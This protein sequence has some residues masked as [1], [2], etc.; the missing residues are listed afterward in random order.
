[1]RY[2][3]FFICYHC[4]LLVII[5]NLF[6]VCLKWCFHCWAFGGFIFHDLQGQ[7]QGVFRPWFTTII[8]LIFYY[9]CKKS[10]Q[11]N[12]LLSMSILTKKLQ[13]V[14]EGD[15]RGPTAS[16]DEIVLIIGCH[17]TFASSASTPPMNK[18]ELK[19]TSPNLYSSVI[20]VCLVTKRV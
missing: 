17:L 18:H 4:D 2:G 15:W 12:I 13:S 8:D 5:I 10:N 14:E 16:K 3:F 11:E 9:T 7:H 6:I 1:M 20:T 19:K